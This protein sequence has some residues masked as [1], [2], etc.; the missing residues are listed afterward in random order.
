M[1]PTYYFLSTNSRSLIYKSG[2]TPHA[3]SGESPEGKKLNKPQE[4]PSAKPNAKFD[5]K[6]QLQEAN[7]IKEFKSEFADIAVKSGVEAILLR[8][9]KPGDKPYTSA[10]LL[11]IKA[12]IMDALQAVKNVITPEQARFLKDVTIVLDPFNPDY[13]AR[14]PDRTILL[15]NCSS[16][17]ITDMTKIIANI[18]QYHENSTVSSA[19]KQVQEWTQGVPFVGDVLKDVL[20][21]SGKREQIR[22]ANEIVS[23]S[24][25]PAYSLDIKYEQEALRKLE[26][27]LSSQDKKKIELAKPL[28]TRLLNRLL[29][30]GSWLSHDGFKLN[31]KFPGCLSARIALEP[32]PDHYAES[33]ITFQ[34]VRDAL[35]V[36]EDSLLKFTPPLEISINYNLLDLKDLE[37]WSKGKLSFEELMR[38]IISSKSYPAIKAWRSEPSP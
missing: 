23:R 9:L 13:H 27:G 22:I 15:V 10:D 3:S 33:A 24:H 6:A 37:R 8:Q 29:A 32:D 4:A 2:E 12:K 5:K 17:S 35:R 1:R 11:P 20:D 19:K 38:T 25:F 34:K 28:A 31:P 30:S 21:E 26:S 18:F 36:G 16:L 14:F 7:R